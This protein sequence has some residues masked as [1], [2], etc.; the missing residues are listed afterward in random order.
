MKFIVKIIFLD[1]DGVLNSWQYDLQRGE[2][3]GNMDSSRLVLLKQLADETD[4]KIVLTSTW[5]HHWSPERELCDRIGCKLEDD[6]EAAGLKIFDKTPD[7]QG[8]RA[9]EIKLWLSSH[10]DI[11]RFV[12]LDDIQFGWRDLELYVVKTNYRI[13]RGLEES[14]IKAAK[15]I[16][17]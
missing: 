4:A 6:F 1:I 9:L 15:E 14:H 8:D 12:V 17:M 11:E 7:F 16:L 2:D 13:G 10:E 3:D 5:R